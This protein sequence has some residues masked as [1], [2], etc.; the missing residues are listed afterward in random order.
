MIFRPVTASLIALSLVGG[1]SCGKKKKSSGAAAVTALATEASEE[2]LLSAAVATGALAINSIDILGVG[3]ESGASL[4]LAGSDFDNDKGRTFVYDSSLESLKQVSGILCFFNQAAYIDM[5]GKGPYIAQADMD[6]CFNEGGE[7]GGSSLKLA[8]A[9]DMASNNQEN[10]ASLRQ[11]NLTTVFVESVRESERHPLIVK[12]WFAMNEGGEKGESSETSMQVKMVI[13]EGQSVQNPL[14]IFKLSWE[15]S[16]AGTVT[17]KGFIEAKRAADSGKISLNFVEESSFGSETFSQSLASILDY[18]SALGEVVGGVIR[19]LTPDY[20]SMGPEGETPETTESVNAPAL[21]QT[22]AEYLA[23]F[24]TTRFLRKS[25]KSGD[26]QCLA[27]DEFDYN[28]YR[29]G[30]YNA[31]DGSRKEINSGFPVTFQQDGETVYGWAGYW[32]VWLGMANITDG[33]TVNRVDYETGATTPYTV[34]AAPGKLMKRTKETMPL[35]KLHGMEFQSWDSTNNRSVIVAYNKNSN[36]FEVIGTQSMNGTT[37][38]LATAEPFALPT[39]YGDKYPNNFWSQGLGGAVIVYSDSQGQVVGSDAYYYKEENVTGSL[40]SDLKLYCY[41]SCLK[42]PVSS[43]SDSYDFGEERTYTFKAGTME[44]IDD[45]TGLVVKI[46]GSSDPYF[47]FASINAMTTAQLAD[48]Y[49]SWEQD[50]TYNY[51]TGTD[52]WSQHI[53]LRDANGQAVNF[54]APLFIKYTHTQANDRSGAAASKYYD[55][56][57]LLN[58][59]GFGNLWG[60]PSGPDANGFWKA[61]FALKDG[62]LIGDANQFKVKALDMELAMKQKELS[63]CGTLA[64]ATPEL[65]SISAFKS[66]NNG[67]A[68]ALTGAPSVVEGVVKVSK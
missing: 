33:I 29:Y 56:P 17:Q 45:T 59:E 14:G 52:S 4:R 48:V 26:S 10:A 24:N 61:N 8:G 12:A 62:A 58:Y 27:K 44:L 16:S 38:Y 46:G 5:A 53:A 40:T 55:K 50:V 32:G 65:P 30:V 34:K 63:E 31:A 28:V 6:T 54:E 42:G 36:A 35:A 19:T 13:A 49:S 15:G 23:A 41:Q 64:T 51:Y 21:A 7:G 2:S 57:Y 9:T 37:E 43:W 1:V 68:P 60:I 18:D 11:K 25:V 66:P 20:S 67:D 47:S 3:S 39:A 22:S